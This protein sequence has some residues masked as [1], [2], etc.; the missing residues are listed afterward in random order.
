MSRESN[1]IFT[2]QPEKSEMENNIQPTPHQQPTPFE[3]SIPIDNAPLPSSGLLY[4]K[5]NFFHMKDVVP[6]KSMTAKEEDI[7]LSKSFVKKGVVVEELIKSCVQGVNVDPYSLVVGDRIA[8]AV[9][10]RIT[11]YGKD[12]DVGVECPNCGHQFNQTFD[13]SELKINRLSEKPIQEGV[14]EFTCKLPVSGV[15]VTYKLLNAY[16]EIKRDQEMELIKSKTGNTTDGLVTATLRRC[17]L[18]VNG[19]RDL[20]SIVRF[21]EQMPARDSK[22][23]RKKMAEVAPGLDFSQDSKCENCEHVSTVRLPISSNLF[24]PE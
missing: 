7:L 8:L 5:E 13:L 14:N 6:I 16:D 10:I 21:V 9:S 23:L 18:S 2:S 4:S 17:V 12:Y 22:F 24:Y 1:D 20:T 19:H 11:G 15:T 3:W